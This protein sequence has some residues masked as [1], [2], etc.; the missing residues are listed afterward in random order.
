MSNKGKTEMKKTRALLAAALII[1]S[2]MAVAHAQEYS[3]PTK[4]LV[5][6]EV[7]P[8]PTLTFGSSQFFP[9]ISFFS[10]T[11]PD[12]ETKWNLETATGDT[13][14]VT[15]AFTPVSGDRYLINASITHNDHLFLVWGTDNT[16][17]PVR[18]WITG[19][20][21]VGHVNFASGSASLDS[22]AKTILRA[23]AQ[24]AKDAELTSVYLVG[25]ADSVGSVASNLSLSEKRVRA[26]YDYLV[27]EMTRIG[28]TDMD[29]TT[30]FMGD[31]ENTNSGGKSNPDDRRVDITLYPN[32]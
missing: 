24:Q 32:M 29:V 14:S 20:M 4:P 5:E 12:V 21:D 28:I 27:A 25:R 11:L 2:S 23:V 31:Y 13:L 10:V 9:V 19:P 30:E 3:F 22:G 26:V 17:R 18:M 6:I 7:A 15:S 1:G 16:P 8:T